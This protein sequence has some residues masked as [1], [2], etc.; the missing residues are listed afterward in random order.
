MLNRLYNALWYPAL[1]FALLAAGGGGDAANRRER[2]GH[3]APVTQAGSPR[4]WMHAASVGEIEAI[5]PVALGLLREHP[6]AVLVVTTMTAPGRDAARN[7]IAGIA[8]A[9][10]APLDCA[11]TVSA[12]LGAVRPDLVIVAET[13]LWPNYFVESR[14]AGARVAI[15][16]GRISGRSVRRYFM[17]RSLFT[18]ALEC[19]DLILA[20]S[21]GDAQRYAILGAPHERIAVTGNTKFD[22][23]LDLDAASPGAPLRPALESFA[24]GRPILVAGSTASGEDPIV[25]AAYLRL[26]AR[27]PALAL[28]VAPRHLDRVREVDD[29]LRSAALSFVHASAAAA[30]DDL[31]AADVMVLDTMGELR[32]IYRRAAVAFVGGSLV[33][34]R[35]GQN[36]AEPAA[37]SVPVLI[38]PH[39]ENQREIVAAMLASGG[40][41]VVRDAAEI[42]DACATLLG[43]DAARIAAGARAREAVENAAG[44]ARSTLMRLRALIT[45]A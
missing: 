18:E 21:E 20:Q 15:I 45:V 42:A 13:E 4:I 34:G 44:G 6:G 19:A 10:L 7:R 17:A 43:D 32:A 24:A 27:F 2:L 29:A 25:A 12:F 8:A 22:I 33:A 36:P 39:H 11:R 3:L 40:G 37:A 14:R 38:G 1:P 31:A 28:I 30:G 35:G 9:T 16:N 26:R 41:F 5:R 23:D